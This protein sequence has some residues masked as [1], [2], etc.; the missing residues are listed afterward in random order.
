MSESRPKP[1]TS[2]EFLAWEARQETRWEFDGFRPVA[3]TGGTVAHSAVVGN[4][5]TA[6]NTSLRGKP[7]RPAGPDLKV[8]IGTKYR[9]PDALVSCVPMALTATVSSEPAVI[10]EVLSAS[11]A[12]EDRTTKMSEYLSLASVQRYVLLEQDRV[13]ATVVG[14]TD[15]GWSL[16]LIGPG[17]IIAMPEIEVEMPIEELYVGLS[18]PDEG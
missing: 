8:Q 11:T 12:A 3:M 18:F 13:F 15:I 5:L 10:F 2:E 4:L 7:C 6:L 16:A 17:G 14:R 9:Y 1:M